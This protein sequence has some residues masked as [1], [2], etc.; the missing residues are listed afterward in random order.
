MARDETAFRRTLAGFF[1]GAPALVATALLGLMLLAVLALPLVSP[2][3]PYELAPADVLDVRLPPG[4]AAKSGS[5]FWLGTDDQGRDILWAIVY[6]LRTSLAVGVLST[7]IALAIGL[8]L[9]LGAAYLGGRSEKVIMRI[10]GVQL[11]FPA[12]LIALLLL[13]VFG[14]GTGRVIAALVIVQWACYA[15]TVRGAARVE[16]G[17]EYIQA[18]HCLALSPARVALHHLLP[19]CLPT[20]LVVAAAQV[21]VAIALEATLSFLGVGVAINEPSLGLLIAN[22]YRD[23]PSGA[24]W[25]GFF[26][27]VA[28]VL[29]IVSINLVAD[30]LRAIL[31]LR[32]QQ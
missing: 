25:I 23:L 19:N 29:T 2:Q 32:L 14:Q 24:Y 20:I 5:T 26:P 6:G 31:G 11:S 30:R 27:G 17:K 28:L 18:A 3:N 8:V 7:L 4:S 9:G 12:F 1:A 13:A 16:M 21:A 15:R 10:A 22:G